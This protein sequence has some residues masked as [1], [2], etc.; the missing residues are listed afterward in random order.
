MSLVGHPDPDRFVAEFT[1]SE[2]TVAEYLLAE[3]LERQPASVRR[4]LMRSSILE[5]INGPLGDLL[6]D[7]TGSERALQ[8]LADTGGFVVAIDAPRT[9]FRFHHL[10]ADLLRVELRNSEPENV[11]HL[12]SL[13][14]GWLAE[15]GFIIEAISHAEQAGDSQQASGLLMEHYF[16]LTLDGRRA[17]A[18]AL[19][20]RLDPATASDS[21]ELAVVAA[22]EQLVDGSLDQ[23]AAHLALADRHR[24]TM[25]ETHEPR[26]EMARLV[27]R[28][29]LTR[30]LGDFR[31]VMDEISSGMNAEELPDSDTVSI[32]T[33]VRALALMN[34]GIVEVWSGRI[35]EGDLHLERAQ[36]LARRIGRPYIEVECQAHLTQVTAWSSFTQAGAASREVIERAEALGWGSDP[37]I[38]PALVTLGTSLLQAGRF[39][40][41]EQW[42]ARADE[43]LRSDLEPA[44]GFQLHLA[45]G[46]LHLARGHHDEA[47]ESFRDAQLLGVLLVDGSPLTRQL[48]AATFRAMLATGQASAVRDALARMSEANRAADE[49][50][51]VLAGLALAD[52]DADA[53]LT[54]LDPVPGDGPTTHDAAVRI[55]SLILRALAHGALE[56]AAASEAAVELALDLA[57]RDTLILPFAHMPSRALLERHP[58]YRTSHGALVT[59]ILDVLSGDTPSAPRSASLDHEALSDAEIRVLRYLPTNLSAEGVAG[60]LYVSVHTVKTHMRHIYAKLDVHTRAEAVSRARELGLIGQSHPTYH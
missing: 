21:R 9:W 52:G 4:L 27:T 47:I 18:R 32:D 33:D 10:F 8:A 6:S 53:A 56:D 49:I 34:L 1:G 43:T 41:A 15:H 22:A 46:G 37:V 45:K 12:H 13:A 60:Q 28:L 19:L 51:E 25:P 23:A 54:Q 17:T 11:A 50:R 14:A 26:F 35:G 29:S 59:L 55:R 48:Q 5:R 57:E 42:L 7:D 20:E 44:V 31:S 24:A 16:S 30:R 36:E 38:A 39:E 40:E 58:R 2:R 3:V